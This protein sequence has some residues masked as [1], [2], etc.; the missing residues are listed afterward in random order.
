MGEKSMVAKASSKS[1]SIRAT[2]PEKIAKE[3]NL[4]VSDVLDWEI[5]V[6]KSR[7]VMIVKKLE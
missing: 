7:K 5:E 4:S 2:I 3:M 6:R 1:P